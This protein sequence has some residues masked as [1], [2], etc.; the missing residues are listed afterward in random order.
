MKKSFYTNVLGLLICLIS[1]LSYAKNLGVRGQLYPISEP[2]LINV[3][4]TRLQSLEQ[5][6]LLSVLQ[7]R[8]KQRINHLLN[9]PTSVQGLS[10]TQQKRVWLYDPTI[11]VPYDLQ[12]EAG[13]IFIA[14]GTVFNPLTRINLQRALL[15]YDASDSEQANWARQIDKMLKGQDKLILTGGSVVEQ[16]RLLQKPIFFDQ[17][18]YLSRR[19]GIQHVPAI[20]VQRGLRLQ[21]SEI[22][23]CA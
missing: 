7:S 10:K 21:I 19:L 16:S 18:G 5:A 22:K 23:P 12:D 4:Q 11:I 6:G 3:I 17:G 9:Q 14:R 2:N 8:W 1:T 20:V 13:H 15:F